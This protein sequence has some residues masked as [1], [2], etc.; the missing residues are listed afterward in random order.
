[1]RRSALSLIRKCIDHLSSEGIFELINGSVNPYQMS[2]QSECYDFVENLMGVLVTV[3]NNE[4]NVEGKE[5]A[6]L[7]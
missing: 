6:L 1:M 4:D 5:Q 7:V 3:F 2:R